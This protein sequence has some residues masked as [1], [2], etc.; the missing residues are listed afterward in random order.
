MTRCLATA[1]SRAACERPGRRRAVAASRVTQ[2]ARSSTTS[3]RSS[4]STAARFETFA[5]RAPVR[6]RPGVRE[7]PEPRRSGA[8][9]H[10][11]RR[12]RSAATFPTPRSCASSR[13]LSA[14]CSRRCRPSSRR[15]SP[16]YYEF[17]KADGGG[18]VAGRRDAGRRVRAARTACATAT[19][20]GPT[21]PPAAAEGAPVNEKSEPIEQF[22]FTDITINAKLDRDM[23]KPSWPVG[24]RRTGRS[25]ESAAGDVEP[26]E[27]GWMVNERAARLRQDHRRLPQAARQARPGGAPRLSPT[28]WSPSPCS[29][30]RAGDAAARS[31]CRRP[32]RHQCLQPRSRRLSA[33]R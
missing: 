24:A 19:S 22:A 16:H 2:A 7:A 28:A 29:S 18:R 27:T 21:P 11:Q 26:K 25:R 6:E 13:A 8:R 15:R 5:P 9:G 17:R 14:T 31:G 3:A 12:P 32:G 23:V 33:S 20:S 10:P 30:S 4:I 1:C